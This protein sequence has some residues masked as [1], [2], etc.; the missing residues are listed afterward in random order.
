MTACPRI[1]I[2]CIGNIFLG[3]DAFGVEVARRLAS[4]Q[5]PDGVRLIDFGIRGY[6]LTL[7]LLDEAHEVIIL[8]DACPR[9]EP[10]G[11][12]YVIEPDWDT[13]DDQASPQT[14]AIDM[15]AL[16]PARVLRQVIA[17]GGRPRRTFLVGCEP[18]PIDPD[19]D[20]PM[21]LSAPVAAAVAEAVTLV[22]S[23]V[24]RVR[25]GRAVG[26]AD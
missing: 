20:P 10:P 5:L 22:E 11:T 19:D 18:T 4:R 8:V 15:H 13:G 3:D 23:L 26:V 9:G 7:A 14:M 24:A 2:A 25:E 6:D 1:L 12:L 16:D 17:M 21:E